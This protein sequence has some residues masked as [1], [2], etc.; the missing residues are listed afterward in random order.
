M[1]PRIFALI[2]AAAPVF[3]AEVYTIDKDHSET[4][5]QVRHIFTKTGGRF[6]DFRGTIRMDRERPEASAVEFRIRAASIDT[7]QP[8]RDKHLRS[9]EFFDVERHP[10][11]VFVST[12]VAPDA[13]NRYRVTGNL[14][15]RGVTR[16]ITLPVTFLGAARDPWG[17]EKAGF[18]TSVTLNRKDFGMVW[19]QALDNGG[20][21]LGDEV[22]VTINLE[23]LRVKPAASAE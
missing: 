12:R 18:E 20:V 17:Q 23:A 3:G 8:D 7:R 6:T 9:A 11:I 5:F 2:L 19:N 14:T 15:M 10:E 13:D 22:W 4:A 1:T 21:I 16:E